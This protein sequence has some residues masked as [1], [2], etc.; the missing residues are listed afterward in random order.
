MI[1]FRSRGLRTGGADALTQFEATGQRI[2][3]SDI[4]G[5]EMD[6]PILQQ[7]RE[8]W[9]CIMR[10]GKTDRKLVNGEV[11]RKC[12]SIPSSVFFVFCKLLVD[13]MVAT[14]IR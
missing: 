8:E 13:C 11:E 14:C 9:G 1:Q 4:E 12:K 6:V 3:S 5:Q 7:E 10:G 2:W